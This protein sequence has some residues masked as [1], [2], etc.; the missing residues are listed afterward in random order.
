MDSTGE[1]QAEEQRQSERKALLQH[2]HDHGWVDETPDA[3]DVYRGATRLLAESQ[4]R[5][6]MLN[7]EE[8]WGE[9]RSQ[10]V[11]GTMPD[12]HANW[13]HRARYALEDFDRVADLTKTLALMRELRPAIEEGGPD[14]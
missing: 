4:A 14:G 11:P 5:R 9:T 8:A 12:Q 1:Q 13:S 2:L 10:N 6:V 7:L 3:A